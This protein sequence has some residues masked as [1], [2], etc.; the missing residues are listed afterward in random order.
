MRVTFI[1]LLASSWW[2]THHKN[3][4]VSSLLNQTLE[5]T[6]RTQKLVLELENFFDKV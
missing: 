1:S 6:K 4:H 5:K 2:H 3:S